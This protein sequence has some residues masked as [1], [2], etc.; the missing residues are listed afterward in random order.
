MFFIVISTKVDLW[1]DLSDCFIFL[2]MTSLAGKGLHIEAV[3][4][5]RVEMSSDEVR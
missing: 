3:V 4:M 5:Y 2:C 1:C